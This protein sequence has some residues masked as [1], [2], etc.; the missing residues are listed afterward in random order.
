L[1]QGTKQSK[2]QVRRAGDAIRNALR[3]IAKQIPLNDK[4]AVDFLATGFILVVLG[5]LHYSK[6]GEISIVRNPENH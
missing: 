3:L 5:I 4:Q 1:G 2:K 6:T